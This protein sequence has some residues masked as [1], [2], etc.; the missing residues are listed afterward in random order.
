MTMLGFFSSGLQVSGYAN[1]R[2]RSCDKGQ[3]VTDYFLFILHLVLGVV[4]ALTT[5]FVEK[6]E[7]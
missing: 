3:T 2:S 4:S 1:E 7:L 5:Y 6:I